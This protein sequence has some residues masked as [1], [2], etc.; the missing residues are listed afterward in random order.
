MP[1][2]PGKKNLWKNAQIEMKH[3]KP[4][5]QAFAIAFSVLRKGKKV[6]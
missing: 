2:F 5:K 1:L 3:G 4:R 6:K